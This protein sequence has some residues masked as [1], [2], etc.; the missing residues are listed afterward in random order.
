MIRF[1]SE[2]ARGR[3]IQVHCGSA[4]SWL[5]VSD[6][7]RAMEAAAHVDQYTVINIGHPD[8][9]PIEGLA[10]RIRFELGAPKSLIEHVDQPGGMTPV[11][12]PVLSRQ[13]DVLGIIPAVSLDEGVRRVCTRVRERINSGRPKS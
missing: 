8:I 1:S 10:E 5:H 2:L 4:R 6:A 7:V 11:K 3:P 9:L 13:H 12:R